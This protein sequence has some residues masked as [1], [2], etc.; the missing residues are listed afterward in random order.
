[1]RQA[2]DEAD[3]APTA[4][5]RV[6]IRDLKRE[7]E[8]VKRE[9]GILGKQWPTSRHRTRGTRESRVHVHR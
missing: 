5:E 6:E 7:L 8:R 9:R 1:M 2:R 4:E 3:G